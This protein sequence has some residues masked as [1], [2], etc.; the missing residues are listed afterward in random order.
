MARRL[1]E[2]GVR[3]VQVFPP[4]KPSVQ[5]WDS[6]N[7][8]YK[9]LREICAKTELPV[10][11][12]IRDLKSRGLLDT[13]IV[14]WAGEFGRL[15]VSQNSSGRDHNRNAFSLWMAGGGFKPGYIYGATDDFGY[16]AV[17]NRVSVPDLHA[18]ILQQLGIDHRKLAYQHNGR[19]ETL[20]DF[21]ATGAKVVNDILAS[22][23]TT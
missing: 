6:H 17:E 1:V 4:I 14:M 20:T 10:A 23:V 7:N 21:P 19:E 2:S 5:P 3:F 12:L 15:P 11:G 18:T 22:T 16:R 9:E 13:T 8:I